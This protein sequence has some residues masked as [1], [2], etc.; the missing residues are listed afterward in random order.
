MNPDFFNYGSLPIYI[1]KGITQFIDSIFHTHTSTYDGMLLIGRYLAVFAESISLLFIY[2][3]ARK[4]FSKII[5][6]KS[7]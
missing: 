7:P 6:I 3:I 2:N 1:L 4:L 5:I